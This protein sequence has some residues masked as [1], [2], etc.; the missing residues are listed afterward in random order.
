MFRERNDGE[1]RGK[2]REGEYSLESKIIVVSEWL[3][4]AGVRNEKNYK[5]NSDYKGG[6]GEG[7]EKIRV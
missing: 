1:G 5:I 7:R 3:R 2:C 4:I 6:M